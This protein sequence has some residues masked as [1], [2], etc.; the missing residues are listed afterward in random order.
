MGRQN[1]PMEDGTLL[2]IGYDPPFGTWFAQHYDDH[3]PDKPPRVAIGYHPAEQD[4][5]RH[6]RPDIILGPYP[7]KTAEELMA[8]IPELTGIKSVPQ[9]E[10]AMCFY[11]GK[12]PWQPGPDD[13]PDHP[14]DRL[15]R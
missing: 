5:A 1:I 6:D 13:C 12:P 15:M 3:D 9:D 10:Q 7:V 4:I 8:L 11:C 14:H 2:V